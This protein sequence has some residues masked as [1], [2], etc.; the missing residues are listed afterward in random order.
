[1]TRLLQTLV[2]VALSIAPNPAIAQAC[3][4]SPCLPILDYCFSAQARTGD[5]AG[6]G[7][8]A[9]ADAERLIGKCDISKFMGICLS[10][11]GYYEQRCMDILP[12]AAIHDIRL[13]CR[14]NGHFC[15]AAR[16]TEG[17]RA[18]PK[19][20]WRR[21]WKSAH[22]HNLYGG[23]RRRRDEWAPRRRNYLKPR[24]LARL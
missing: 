4:G 18:A 12:F 11:P 6:M 16:L 13:N 5:Y 7:P 21:N 20:A 8:T 10:W 17:G 1:M 9:L 2:A 23:A 24:W 3:D 19:P 14:D 15:G 22:D